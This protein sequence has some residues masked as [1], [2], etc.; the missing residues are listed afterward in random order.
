MNE[1]HNK[2]HL[3]LI[4]KLIN[5]A[6]TRETNEIIRNNFDYIDINFLKILQQ[7]AIRLQQEGNSDTGNFLRNILSQL[8]D[9]LGIEKEDL[10]VAEVEY[11]KSYVESE[12]TDIFNFE[13][14][15]P[16]NSNNQ[17]YSDKERFLFLNDIFLYIDEN[18]QEAHSFLER[19]INKIDENLIQTINEWANIFYP[20]H[21]EYWLQFLLN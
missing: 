8:V 3:N 1:Q 15:K 19:N 16:V 9:F 4:K 17:S 10:T 6:N 14:T 20:N 2:N 13:K 5:C 18:P 21:Q 7:E 11:P 12:T